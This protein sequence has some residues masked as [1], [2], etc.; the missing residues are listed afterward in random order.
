GGPVRQITRSSGGSMANW[1][2]DGTALT[3]FNMNTAQVFVMRRDQSGR[4]GE[5]RVVGGPGVRPEWSPDG[6]T[7]AFVSPNDGRIRIVP[8]DSGTQR[9]LYVPSANG[10]LAEL[11]VFAASGRELYFK[12]H[13]ARGRA[14]FWSISTAGGRP[15]LLARL[16][17]SSHVSN[18]F[19][20]ASDGKR[21]YFT[22]EDRQSDIWLAEVT[23]HQP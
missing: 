4:W 2:P 17:D 9:D 3:F 16:D 11:A 8:A 20:F 6:Q 7:I 23:P 10:P 22:I 15:R 18:R 19:E 1:S 13:D 12:S 5:P 14:S 21:F